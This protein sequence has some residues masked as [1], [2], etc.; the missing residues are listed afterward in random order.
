MKVIR[1]RR[2][3]RPTESLYKRILLWLNNR[4]LVGWI[5]QQIHCLIHIHQPESMFIGQ[6][7]FRHIPVKYEYIHLICHT[8]QR[9]FYH[10]EI[11]NKYVAK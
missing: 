10:K 6:Y 8:C 1:F 5:K 2:L 11:K 4:L 9:V 3:D 7:L